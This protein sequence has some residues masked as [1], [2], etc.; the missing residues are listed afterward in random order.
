MQTLPLQCRY[1][2]WP[3]LSHEEDLRC[4]AVRSP[5]REP[6]LQARVH[7]VHRTSDQ[8]V[9]NCLFDEARLYWA[10]ASHMLIPS[11]SASHVLQQDPLLT[12]DLFPQE[13]FRWT[14]H[15]KHRDS[16]SYHPFSCTF[17]AS[18]PHSLHLRK[19]FFRYRLILPTQ[20]VYVHP[21]NGLHL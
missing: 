19:I 5:C 1:I 6:Q 7:P 15:P 17:I 18:I 4:C 9:R 10:V 3:R 11:L 13:P 12:Q 20:R 21:T 2:A 14:Q 16:A 8:A